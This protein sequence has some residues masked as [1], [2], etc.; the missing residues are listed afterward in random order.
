MSCIY[1]QGHRHTGAFGRCQ[2]SIYGSMSVSCVPHWSMMCLLFISCTPSTSMY[3]DDARAAVVPVCWRRV[4]GCLDYSEVARSDCL[5]PGNAFLLKAGGGWGGGSF[6][7][8]RGSRRLR[9]IS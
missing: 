5:G 6:L 8:P 2:I 1:I 4:E 9:S 7:R 3:L